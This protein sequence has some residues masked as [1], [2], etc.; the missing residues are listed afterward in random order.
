MFLGRAFLGVY[1]RKASAA[2]GKLAFYSGAKSEYLVSPQLLVVP[3]ESA[4]SI[5]CVKARTSSAAALQGHNPRETN[6]TFVSTQ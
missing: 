3:A 6:S 5:S 2:N 1:S 4:W